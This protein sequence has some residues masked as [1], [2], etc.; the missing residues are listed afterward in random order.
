MSIMNSEGESEDDAIHEAWEQL[1]QD[2]DGHEY[3]DQELY[4]YKV[5]KMKED[6]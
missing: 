4:D 5:T 6:G 1:Y 2:E 3:G